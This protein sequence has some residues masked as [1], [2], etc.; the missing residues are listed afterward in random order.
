MDASKAA[1]ALRQASQRIAERVVERYYELRPELKARYGPEGRAR[2]LEDA[3]YHLRYLAEA[4]EEGSPPLLRDYLTWAKILFASL[5]L[6]GEMLSL[7]FAIIGEAISEEL[8]G[9]EAAQVRALLDRGIAEVTGLP[10]VSES[11]LDS[12]DPLHPLCCRYI[13]LLREGGKSDALRL[14]LEAVR[15]GT[16]LEDIYLSVLQPALREVG[17]LWQT[18]QL[19]VAQEH[20]ATAITQLVLA[21]LAPALFAAGRKGRRTLLAACVGGELHEMGARILADVFELSGWRTVYL[22]A[23]TPDSAFVDAVRREH[24]ELIGI[25]ATMAFHLPE[26]RRVVSVVRRASNGSKTAVMVGGHPF[27]VVEGLWRS[28]GADGT[29]RD[30]RAALAEAERLLPAGGT[31]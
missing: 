16:P 28:V 13:Q 1:A 23:N 20:F 8:P 17:R 22:G 15:D 27:N 26:V 4:V 30:A 25:S 12:A 19:S 31:P 11:M 9:E 10:A 2:S 14:V 7:T 3:S 6:P 21:R 24:P 5:G 29:A 18:G